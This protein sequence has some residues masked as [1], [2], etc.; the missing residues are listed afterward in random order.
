[1]DVTRLQVSRH[2]LEGEVDTGDVCRRCNV[3]LQ[4]EN[5]NGTTL[6]LQRTR[7]N[8][9]I[10]QDVYSP[11]VQYLF[12]K[13]EFWQKQDPKVV[14]SHGKA[15]SQEITFFETDVTF[16]A[17]HIP[18]I[19]TLTYQGRPRPVFRGDCAF[20]PGT[21]RLSDLDRWLHGFSFAQ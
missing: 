7:Q 4:G 20:A 14:I 9:V 19:R 13:L 8:L 6:V 3:F 15:A 5:F 16:L 17:S 11:M 21:M 18:T 10:Q 2:S 12:P 1:M